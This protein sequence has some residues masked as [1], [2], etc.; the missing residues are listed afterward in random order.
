M[1]HPVVYLVAG[2]IPDGIIG[3]FNWTNPSNR[4]MSLG[5]RQ[6]VTEM[7]TSNLPGGKGRPTCKADNLTAICEPI[8]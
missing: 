2:S 6:P 1:G 4:T 5:L 8:V 3:F 7:S